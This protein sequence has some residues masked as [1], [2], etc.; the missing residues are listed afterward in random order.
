MEQILLHL[1]GDYIVQKSEWALNKKKK[2]M[3][4]FWCC[5]IHVLTYTAPFLLIG[6]W[7]AVVV[8]GV[9]HFIIDRTKI[10]DKFISWR[11]STGHTV[12]FGYAVERPFAIAVW[13]NIIVDNIFHVTINYLALKY[14]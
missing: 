4:G 12:N 14:L 13:L 7:Q 8:I 5:L 9:T 11:N 6:S 2:G 3:Y 10:I 1:W